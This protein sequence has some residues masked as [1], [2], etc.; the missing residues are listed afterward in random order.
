[1][2]GVPVWTYRYQLDGLAHA[3]HPMQSISKSLSEGPT[4]PVVY[5]HAGEITGK[6]LYRQAG[7]AAV[8]LLVQSEMPVLELSCFFTSFTASFVCRSYSLTNNGSLR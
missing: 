2:Y 1:M 7:R 8:V 5:W 6:L 3:V 4:E